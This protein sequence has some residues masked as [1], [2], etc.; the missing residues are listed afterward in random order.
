[1]GEVHLGHAASAEHRAQLVPAAEATRLF[2]SL[3]LVTPLP[4]LKE[5]GFQPEGCGPA[6]TD[7]L[8]DRAKLPQTREAI[9]PPAKA[10]GPLARRLMAACCSGLP[11]PPGRGEPLPDRPPIP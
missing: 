9:P 10:G 8:R 4:H 3:S 1:M 5:G 11:Y 7:P 6:R 2:H